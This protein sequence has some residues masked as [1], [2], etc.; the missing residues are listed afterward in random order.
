MRTRIVL[1][2]ASLQAGNNALHHVAV[3]GNAALAKMLLASGKA[4][5]Q[6]QAAANNSGRTPLHVAAALGRSEVAQLLLQHKQAGVITAAD[7]VSL[8]VCQAVVNAPM[9]LFSAQSSRHRTACSAVSRI[10]DGYLVMLAFCHLQ[11]T[12]R[13]SVDHQSVCHAVCH[14]LQD[15]STILHLVAKSL[16]C[17]QTNQLDMAQAM[18]QAGANPAAVDAVSTA[19]SVDHTCSFAICPISCCQTCTELPAEH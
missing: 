14:R 18:I 13:S 11:A 4:G 8:L 15:G 17:N 16:L 7:K 1:L 6:A 9:N 3:S 5:P 12:Q 10:M 2:F 19:S